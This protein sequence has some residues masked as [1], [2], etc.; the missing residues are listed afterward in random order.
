M[1]TRAASTGK[2]GEIYAARMLR[3]KGDYE[4]IACDYRVRGGEIDLIAIH[5][6]MLVCAEVKARGKNAIGEPREW[7]TESKRHKLITAAKLFLARDGRRLQP[8]FDVIEVWLDDSSLPPKLLKINHIEN[9][10]SCED[11]IF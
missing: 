4:L 9:A 1:Y 2:W 3:E 10:F 7:V 11:E 8:R 5:K 6:E